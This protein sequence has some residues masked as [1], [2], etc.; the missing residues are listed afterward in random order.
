MV[1]EEG[2]AFPGSI[3]NWAGGEGINQAVCLAFTISVSI[4][5]KAAQNGLCGQTEPESI[6]Q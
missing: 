6:S 2:Q 3:W 5:V 4:L 1:E